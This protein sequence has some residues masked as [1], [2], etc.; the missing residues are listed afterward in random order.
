MKVV[1]VASPIKYSNIW[2]DGHRTHLHN[3]DRFFYVAADQVKDLPQVLFVKDFRA[4]IYKPAVYSEC[5]R[6]RFVGHRAN[7]EEC[8]AKAPE[9]VQQSTEAFQGAHNPLSNLHKC[10]EGCSWDSNQ[11]V[12]VCSSEHEFQYEKLVEHSHADVAERLCEESPLD[13]MK[14]A[15]RKV[16]EPNVLKSWSDKERFVMKQACQNKF[17]NC[18]H[19]R[20]ALLSSKSELAEATKDLK[21]GTGLDKQRTIECMPEYWPGNNMMGAILKEIRSDLLEELRLSQMSNRTEKRKDT[22]PPTPAFSKAARQ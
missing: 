21:W 13:M 5:S 22:S 8:P 10:P 11:D 2:I 20:A 12:E 17:N 15:S 7:S 6:C 9:E 3:G 4:R 16:P 14:V 1:T 18:E 19:A